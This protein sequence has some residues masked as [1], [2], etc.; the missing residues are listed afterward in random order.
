MSLDLASGETTQVGGN[1]TGNW[2]QGGVSAV[3]S[4]YDRC[5]LMFCRMVQTIS[6]PLSSTEY[7][8]AVDLT[9]GKLA[10]SLP[11]VNGWSLQYYLP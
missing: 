5:N 7:L 8:V 10:Y 6:S 4:S 3:I 11:N 9:S 2:T 1:F